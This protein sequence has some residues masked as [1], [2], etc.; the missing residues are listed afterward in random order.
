[1][2]EQG[3]AMN[4]I[5]ALSLK[6]L[7]SSS[8]Q[9]TYWLI[10]EETGNTLASLYSRFGI[11]DYELLFLKTRY[12]GFLKRS[13]IVL[14]VNQDSR[15]ILE[16]FASDARTAIAPGVM[17]RS[18]EPRQKVLDHLRKC[19]SVKFYGNRKGMM[20]FYHPD[21]AALL[22]SNM[23]EV[24]DQ[25]FGPLDRW[26][27]QGA[28]LNMPLGDKLPWQAV[29]RNT[30]TVVQ[31]N[32]PEGSLSLTKSQEQALERYIR[33]TS[34]FQQYRKPHE[35]FDDLAV[36]KRFLESELANQLLAM[37]LTYDNRRDKTASGSARSYS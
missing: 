22:F 37:D 21:V 19:L 20:R 34:V 12:S 30:K 32:L 33:I 18:S 29:T 1:M 31:E 13:P 27:W 10:L 24:S 26:V 17:V 2:Q 16:A 7:L 4:I 9:S 8:D 5:S 3:S 14:P 25:W 6:E 35:S 36:R 15:Q 11:I 28:E 23:S